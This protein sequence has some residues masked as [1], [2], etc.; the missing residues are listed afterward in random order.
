M[1][2]IYAIFYIQ[3]KIINIKISFQSLF[4]SASSLL[5]HETSV[6]VS[7]VTV[8]L[9]ASTAQAPGCLPTNLRP[10]LRSATNQRPESGSL[11]NQRPESGSAINQRPDYRPIRGLS[12][13]WAPASAIRA[14]VS[15]RPRDPVFGSSAFSLQVCTFQS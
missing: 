2:H 10:V 12:P 5:E 6:P 1:L 9:P 13:I 8:Q 14:E 15:L 4:G 11:T 3:N 7:R